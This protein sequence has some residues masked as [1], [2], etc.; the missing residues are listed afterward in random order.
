MKIVIG[1]TG[2]QEYRT[3][4]GCVKEPEEEEMAKP[5]HS[6]PDAQYELKLKGESNKRVLTIQQLTA[7][8]QSLRKAQ[9]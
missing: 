8:L 6:Y 2:I 7:S 5:P 1:S 3:Q 4:K 9:S